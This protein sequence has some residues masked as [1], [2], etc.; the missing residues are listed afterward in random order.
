MAQGRIDDCKTLVRHGEDF[1]GACFSLR[2]C[3]EIFLLLPS[4]IFF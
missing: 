4:K 3:G 1:G 2:L